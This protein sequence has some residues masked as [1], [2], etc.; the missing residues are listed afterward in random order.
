MR[1]DNFIVTGMISYD[2]LCQKSIDN[3]KI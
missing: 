2:C 3:V 1:G